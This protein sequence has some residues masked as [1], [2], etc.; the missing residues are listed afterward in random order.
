MSASHP[1][2]SNVVKT[3][4]M[5]FSMTASP[6]R[7]ASAAASVIHALGWAQTIDQALDMASE[8][9]PRLLQYLRIKLNEYA[10]VGRPARLCFNSSAS[11]H[12]QGSC[13]I[14][15]TDTEDIRQFKRR[16]G[17][18][19]TYLDAIMSLDPDAFER[20][21]AKTL[22]LLGVPSPRTTRR[23][24]DEG[25]DF[26]GQVDARSMFYPKDLYPTIQQQLT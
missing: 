9:E 12:I 21:C 6:Q 18:L 15:P 14:E 8:W 16:R 7:I 20:L 3:W 26:Y 24:G 17:S 25:I 10:E 23:T 5:E 19:Q 4:L 2:P 11:D 22:T 13:F 1:Q